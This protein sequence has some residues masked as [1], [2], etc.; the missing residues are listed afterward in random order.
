MCCTMCIARGELGLLGELNGHHYLVKWP[1]ID[2]TKSNYTKT[3]NKNL[4][5]AKVRANTHRMRT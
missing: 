2:N 3:G 5:P 1:F 4:I